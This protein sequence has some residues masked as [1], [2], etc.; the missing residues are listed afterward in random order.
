MFRRDGRTRLVAWATLAAAILLVG[1]AAQAGAEKSAEHVQPN[2]VGELDC[3]GFSPIQRSVKPT[4]LCADP[5]L[6]RTVRLEDHEHYIGHDEPSIRFLSSRPGSGSNVTWVER[7]G[8]D[9]S[10]LPTVSNPGSDVTHNFEL[11]IAPWMSMELCDPNSDPQ[12]PCTPRSDAN[13]PNGSYPGGGSAFMELQFYPPGFAPFLDSIS[14]DNTHWCSALTI[15]SVACTFAGPCN[16]NCIE[17]VNFAFIQTNGV[18]TGPPSPQKSNNATVHAQLAHVPDEPGRQDRDPHVGRKGLGRTRPRDHRARRD[19]GRERQDD[20]VCRQRLHDHEHHRLQRDAVQL[21]AGVQH[22][23]AAEHRPLGLWPLRHQHPVRDRA[24]R[25]VHEDH[26]AANA[27]VR[28]VPRRLLQPVP[29][30]LRGRC[31]GRQP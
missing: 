9:P 29:R 28:L 10:A 3:N 16:D 20:R 23:A 7:L 2:K 14:C 18:P 5:S 12:L 1:G 11:T 25:A 21:R 19:H 30:P 13:A 15:D 4:M 17:P 8:K 27:P 22:G 31:A 6:S 24:L 26:G